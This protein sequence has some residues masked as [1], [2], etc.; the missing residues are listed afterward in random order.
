MTSVRTCPVIATTASPL[1]DLLGEAGL[2]FDP[3]GPAALEALLRK[4]LQ[5]EMLRARMRQRGLA[6]VA[7]L[8]WDASARQ[9]MALIEKIA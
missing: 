1:P 3:P 4:V 2:Y 6:A 5:S 9:M 7:K 8:S